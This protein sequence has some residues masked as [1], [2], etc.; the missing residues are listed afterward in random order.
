GTAQ[1]FS[2][3][4]AQS[5]VTAALKQGLDAAGASTISS[6]GYW[7]AVFVAMTGAYFAYVG[8]AASTFVAGEVKEANKTL[9][10]VLLLSSVIIMVVYVSVSSLAAYASA[11]LGRVTLPNGDIWSFF[12]AYAYLSYGAGDLAK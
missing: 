6:G 1:G 3:V 8:Y 11:A 10:R 2:G 4:T 7:F 5:Y 12:E 9:P